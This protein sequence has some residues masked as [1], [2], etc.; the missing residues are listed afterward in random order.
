MLF[1]VIFIMLH[2][3]TDLALNRSQ[4]EIVS[5]AVESARATVDGVNMINIV[6]KSIASMI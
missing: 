5:S 4:F 3:S 2:F 1:F 6:N